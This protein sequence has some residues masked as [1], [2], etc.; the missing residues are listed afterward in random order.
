MHP[1]QLWGPSNLLCSRYGG[2]GVKVTIR[3]NL[4]PP[5]GI[6]RALLHPPIRLYSVVLK[7][8]RRQLYHL[9]IQIA[10]GRQKILDP[11]VASADWLFDC[12]SFSRECGFYLFMSFL[13]KYLKFIHSQTVYYLLLYCVVTNKNQKLDTNFAKT[14]K[15]YQQIRCRY[16]TRHTVFC[17]F[18]TQKCTKPVRTSA[19]GRIQLYALYKESIKKLKS[20]TMFINVSQRRAYVTLLCPKYYEESSLTNPS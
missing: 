1:Y 9:R 13:S 10:R 5:L 19:L 8:A 7:Q 15:R 20:I 14:V 4:V 6:C 11:R 16:E 3:L 2:R 18:S 12:S 17:W